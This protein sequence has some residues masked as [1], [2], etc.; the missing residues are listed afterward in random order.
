MKEPAGETNTFFFFEE[1][2]RNVAALITRRPPIE[3][4]IWQSFWQGLSHFK[5][6]EIHNAAFH[7]SVK[8][9]CSA[10][11]MKGAKK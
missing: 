7:D 1:Y 6:A 10:N 3:A 8:Y 2:R 11:Q 9:P 4:H 5:A